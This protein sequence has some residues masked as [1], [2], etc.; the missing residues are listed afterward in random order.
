MAK[1]AEKLHRNV[2]RI[3]ATLCNKD[4]GCKNVSGV[5]RGNE[6]KRN[7]LVERNPESLLWR[8]VNSPVMHSWVCFYL[9]VLPMC[10]YKSVTD[11]SG[12]TKTQLRITFSA[13][14]DVLPARI[15]ACAANAGP[16][17][18]LDFFG[19]GVWRGKEPR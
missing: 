6:A 16:T 14:Y 17:N 1:N 5:S 12:H 10:P 8:S 9:K 13:V 2:R 7:D 11:V 19:W 4:Q 18:C 15:R 3:P